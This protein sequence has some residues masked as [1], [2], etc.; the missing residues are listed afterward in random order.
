MP[1]HNLVPTCLLDY[2]TSPSMELSSAHI[3][4]FQQRVAYILQLCEETEEWAA[5]REQRAYAFLDNLDVDI[6]V[7]LA[8]GIGREET[9]DSTYLIHSSWTTDMS[10]AAM[11]E[12]LPKELVS[13][14]CA[15]F[16]RFLLS[17][18][19][20]DR[21]IVEWSQHLRRVLDAFAISTTADA[22][23]GRVLA[24]DLLLQKMACFITILRFNTMIE[25]Y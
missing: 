17:N 5:N 16:D 11:Y 6:N 2:M 20:V 19:E 15:G 1:Q 25:R 18:A 9:A 22:A 13:Y 8:S 24:M 3:K 23:M 14:L 12:S 10:T 21:W 4:S 7:I